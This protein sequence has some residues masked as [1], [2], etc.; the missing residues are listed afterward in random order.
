MAKL[1][2]AAAILTLA[3]VTGGAAGGAAVGALGITSAAG[4]FAAGAITGG[5][6]GGFGYQYSGL[7]CFWK[8]FLLGAISGGLAGGFAGLSAT[9]LA[10]GPGVFFLMLFTPELIHMGLDFLDVLEMKYNQGQPRTIPQET[11]YGPKK[12]Y[13][14][15]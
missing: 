3:A 13:A 10:I 14:C 5:L 6:I 4:G 7:G 15:S 1:V 11:P 8:G 9:T 12:A 2:T